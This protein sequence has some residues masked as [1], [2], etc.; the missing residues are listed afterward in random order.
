MIDFRRWV[1]VFV[2][3]ML[4]LFLPSSGSEVA[5]EEV[6]ELTLDDAVERALRDGGRAKTAH[7]EMTESL[8]EAA[9]LQREHET[10]PPRGQTMTLPGPEGPV[11]IT[12]GAPSDFEKA[13]V[14][15]LLP[16]QFAM[17]RDVARTRYES[18]MAALR[19]DVIEL[20][21]AALLADMAVDLHR[22]SLDRLEAHR[23]QAETLYS[24]GQVAEIDVVR[25]RAEWSAGEAELVSA[26]RTRDRA[27]TALLDITGMDLDARVRLVEPGIAP[28]GEDFELTDDIE[29]AISASPE[30][31]SAR[32]RLELAEKE[33]ELFLEHRGGYTRRR[34]YRE[35]SLAI[36]QAEH[37]LIESKRA[38]QMQVRDLHFRLAEMESRR[39]ALSDQ[40][41]LASRA[42]EVA[43]VQYEAGLTTVTDVLDSTVRLREAELAG[44]DAE[45]Q[46]LIARAH[47]D[48]LMGEGVVD[49]QYDYQKVL[50]EIEELR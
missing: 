38:V 33:E 10:G 2:L 16:L 32:G 19:A 4:L 9:N 43:S 46:Y 30:V 45:I 31:D 26:E 39:E 48:S 7:L 21:Y 5:G 3:G 18:Q 34:S 37:A 11:R 49:L 35:R 36:E 23:S 29:R 20:Y 14:E 47:R 44:R 1:T 24:E 41:G 8:L 27:L 15:K 40:V 42:A 50:A 25:A 13:Q 6:Q 22:D 12:V 28:S 17:V